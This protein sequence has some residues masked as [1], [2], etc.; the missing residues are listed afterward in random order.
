MEYDGYGIEFRR[1]SL[2]P[3]RFIS[4]FAEECLDAHFT[5]KRFKANPADP[6]YTP[7]S[8]PHT[9]AF[10]DRHYSFGPTLS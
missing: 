6:H 3:L 7:P 10:P 2:Y 1:P 9:T 8:V 4:H 5:E